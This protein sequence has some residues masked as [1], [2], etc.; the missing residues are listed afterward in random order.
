MNEFWL[1]DDDDDSYAGPEKLPPERDIQVSRDEEYALKA[2]EDE[3]DP[4]SDF[5]E[6]EENNVDEG[7]IQDMETD[8]EVETQAEVS[9]PGRPP[10]YISEE[11]EENSGEISLLP[12]PITQLR[13][14]SQKRSSGRVTMPS[15]RLQGYELY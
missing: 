10:R 9:R 15:S 12:S 6:D 13:E 8:E 1:D 7:G 11:R 4:I 2:T 3:F 5:E 14:G